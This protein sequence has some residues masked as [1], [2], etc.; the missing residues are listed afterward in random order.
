MYLTTAFVDSFVYRIDTE[1]FYK[2][3]LNNP[4]QTHPTQDRKSVV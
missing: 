4:T 1:D 2:D 3:L